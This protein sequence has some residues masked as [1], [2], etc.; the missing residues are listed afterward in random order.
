MNSKILE[1]NITVLSNTFPSMKKEKLKPVEIENARIDIARDRTPVLVIKNNG[2][3]IYTNSKYN[4]TAEAE[5]WA[6]QFTDIKQGATCF[7]FG[8][9]NT[10]CVRALLELFP[11]SVKIIVYEPDKNNFLS[12]IQEVSIIELIDC[13]R[14]FTVVNGINEEDM[15][16][17]MWQWIGWDN[18][19]TMKYFP[20]PK[21]DQIY[22]NEYVS[23]LNLVR[24]YHLTRI[25]QVNTQIYHSQ[26]IQYNLKYNLKY[27]LHSQNLAQYKNIIPE[28]VPV[29][30]VAAGPSLNKNVE[31]LKNA[32]GRAVIIAT[33]TA[34]KVLLREGIIPDLFVTV[35]PSKNLAVFAEERVAKI[36]V[37]YSLYSNADAL[38]QHIGIK[39][40]TMD[41]L[42]YQKE[43]MRCAGKEFEELTSGGSVTTIALDFARYMGTKKV[44]IIGL[45]LA[46]TGGRQHAHGSYREIEPEIDEI[47]G[48]ALAEDIYGNSVWIRTDYYEY[49]RWTEKWILRYRDIQVFDATEGGVR[50]EGTVITT[51]ESVIKEHCQK[52]FDMSAIIRQKE[53]FFTQDEQETITQYLYK[54]PEDLKQ[55]Q[56]YAKEN[57]MYNKEIQ[58]VIFRKQMEVAKLKTLSK[59]TS[60]LTE[61]IYSYPLIDLLELYMK[62]TSLEVEQNLYVEKENPIEEIKAATEKSILWLDGAVQA[63]EKILPDMEEMLKGVEAEKEK[64]YDSKNL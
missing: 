35:D 8:L 42:D 43:I 24:E 47:G 49:L 25:S 22:P 28:E 51:L 39:I 3:E 6:K 21:Y 45:D 62:K 40:L 41:D 38:I 10:S 1:D 50:I 31:R 26:R 44:I 20:H 57:L 29:V 27:L 14:L 53:N 12:V 37:L 13:E 60:M 17:I 18:L 9:G 54:I 4:P 36:P 61:K 16:D 64:W 55:I 23:F 52:E 33:D 59:K 19:L 7:M 46:Y 58:K 48:G 34:L 5:R 11:E 2:K 15:F 63:I 32:Q 30:V 56:R